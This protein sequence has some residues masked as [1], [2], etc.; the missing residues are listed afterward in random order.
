MKEF[1]AASSKPGRKRAR[2]F[3][4]SELSTNSQYRFVLPGERLHELEWR[5]CLTALNRSKP[6]PKFIVASGSLPPGAPDDFYAQAAA[7]ARKL[8]AKFFLDTS[9]VPLAAALEYGVDLIKPNLREIRDL[10]GAAL[11]DEA[12]LIAGR[13]PQLYRRRKGRN[14]RT[15]ARSS[16]CHSHHAGASS[17]IAA[18]ADQAG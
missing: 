3:R 9:V 18:T 5:E 4:F 8:G 16:R 12:D 11:A 6:V 17:A 14:R 13:C 15:I 10:T 7:M 1:R 2:T